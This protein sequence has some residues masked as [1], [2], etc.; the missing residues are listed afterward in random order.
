MRSFRNSNENSKSE[1]VIRWII[2]Q[3]VENIFA[4]CVMMEII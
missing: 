2:R 3:Y 4:D 1:L